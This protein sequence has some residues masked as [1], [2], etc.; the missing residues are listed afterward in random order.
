MKNRRQ[1]NDGKNAKSIAIAS[2]IG[3]TAVAAS[4]VAV[5]S[6]TTRRLVPTSSS[7]ESLWSYSSS[8]IGGDIPV[9]NDVSGVPK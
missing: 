7:P 4:L 1:N 9:N 5:Y 6:S 2:A 3:L 8:K